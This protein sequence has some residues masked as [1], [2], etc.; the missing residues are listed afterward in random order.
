[1]IDTSYELW[2]LI[3]YDRQNKITF[4]LKMV[5]LFLPLSPLLII[6]RVLKSVSTVLLNT[7]G[8]GI[9]KLFPNR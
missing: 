8:G 6:E 7:L 4:N 2:T 9:S 1:M 3:V 5:F